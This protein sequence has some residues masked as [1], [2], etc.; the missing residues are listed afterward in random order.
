MLN[1]VEG[2][3]AVV[4]S[5]S[6][7]FEPLVVHYAETFVV[8]ASVGRYRVRPLGGAQAPLATIKAYVRE[9]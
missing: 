2:Q 8:P 4:E 5:P 6:A 7:D 1:L 9:S 3:A